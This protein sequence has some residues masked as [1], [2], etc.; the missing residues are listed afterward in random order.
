LMRKKRL[1][2][3]GKSAMEKMASEVRS[4]VISVL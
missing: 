2:Q 1:T 4:V 3:R